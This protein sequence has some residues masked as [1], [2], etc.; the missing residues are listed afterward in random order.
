MRYEIL[1]DITETGLRGASPASYWIA[2]AVAVLVGVWAIFH[3][4]RRRQ[5]VPVLVG[6]V[7]GGFFATFAVRAVLRQSELLET[8]RAGRVQVV[9]GV[10]TDFHPRPPGGKGTESFTVGGVHFEY[11]HGMQAAG[12]TLDPLAGGPIRHGMH[13]RIAHVDGR[14]LKLEAVRQN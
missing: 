6:L 4:V 11:V 2:S 13:V 12:F 8:A 3:G 7:F 9:E 5:V 10:V 1:Y 14:I